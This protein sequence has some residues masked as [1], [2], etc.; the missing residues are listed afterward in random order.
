MNSSCWRACCRRAWKC[1]CSHARTAIEFERHTSHILALWSGQEHAQAAAMQFGI[2]EITKWNGIPYLLKAIWEL[3][4]EEPG[5]S[6]PHSR[7]QY[8]DGDSEGTPFVS[9]DTGQTA[10]RLLIRA[11]RPIFR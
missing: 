4:L 11:I 3:F 5:C 8:I 1:L 10:N 7:I 2:A 6:R 9:R